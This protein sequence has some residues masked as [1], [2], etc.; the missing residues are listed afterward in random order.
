[1]QSKTTLFSLIILFNLLFGCTK[2]E[3]KNSSIE[4]SWK[5]LGY[6]KILKIDSSA[7]KYYDLTDISCLPS[8]QG[9]IAEVKH[10]IELSN[11]TLTVKRGYS[12]Y[13]Y[14]RINDLPELCS[15]NGGKTNDPLYNFEVFA[16]TYKKHYAYF[17]LNGIN[18]ERLYSTSKSKLTSSTSEVELYLL[19]QKM[20]DSLNDNHGYIEPT[21][22]VYEMVQNQNSIV[23]K[24]EPQK[25]Y[26][27]FEIAELV[28]EHHIDENLTKDSWLVKWGKMEGNIGYIQV[29]AMWLFADINLPESLVKEHGFVSTY[30]DEFD[31]L[32]YAKQVEL[33][34]KGISSIMDKVMDDL[35]ETKFIILDVR[36]NGGGQDEVGL[37]VLRRFNGTRRQIASKKARYKNGFTKKTVIYLESSEK[38]YTKPVYMLTSQQSASATDMMA[39]SSLE[40]SQISR[41]GSHTNGA[42]SDALQKR[43][44]NGWYL[45]LSNEIY[46]DNND[47]HYENIGIPVDFELNYRED[48]QTFFRSVTNDLEKDKKDILQAIEKLQNK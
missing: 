21:D 44:P 22:K 27:D 11:D 14:I 17:E 40:L 31:K 5:S 24:T 9:D 18:W 7:Y 38:P 1:M 4:G 33:E 13:Q 46:T 20:I 25:E 6:G 47:K 41:I 23:E 48:R 2:N 19:M 34:V 8:K 39:L 29:N 10:S 45:S 36:F 43:L 35:F 12:V 28:A 16:N 30:I 32:N 15:V 37:E 3:Q 26:G 42:I